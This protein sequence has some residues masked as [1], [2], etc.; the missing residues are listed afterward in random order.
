MLWVRGYFWQGELL[1]IVNSFNLTNLYFWHPSTPR[2]IHI[3]VVS[4][5][6]AWN[7]IALLWDGAAMVNAHS[8]P[9][10]IVANV[11]I[12]SI[13][14]VGV[15][16]ILIFGDSSMGIELAILSLGKLR[17]RA[18]LLLLTTLQQSPSAKLK[19]TSLRCN[20]SLL[21][22][23]QA[24]SCFYPFL[25]ACHRCLVK[26]GPFVFTESL[27]AKIQNE[28]LCWWTIKDGLH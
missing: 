23:S 4:A 8:L 3:P 19:L 17:I 16:F 22:S 24:L 6:L 7:Y 25:S 2:W 12:W 13:L 5:P 20:G 15:F 10:R 26:V 21:L 11:F 18:M 9:A 14:G 28:L 1:L 27:L